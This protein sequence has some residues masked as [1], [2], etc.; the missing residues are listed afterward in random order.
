MLP[1]SHERILP[2][3]VV[4]GLAIAKIRA[5]AARQEPQLLAFL[6]RL[7]ATRGGSPGIFG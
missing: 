1:P 4:V 5:A 7:G 3:P 6:A 2:G